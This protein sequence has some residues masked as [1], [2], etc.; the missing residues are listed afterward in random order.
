LARVCP[1]QS[2]IPRVSWLHPSANRR[3]STWFY[4][5]VLTSARVL[6]R[7]RSAIRVAERGW[8]L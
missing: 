6:R 5:D 1:R 8:A 4:T 7:D 2:C 3:H